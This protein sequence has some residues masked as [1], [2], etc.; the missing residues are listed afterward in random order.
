MVLE[1]VSGVRSVP[2]ND[3]ISKESQ[4]SP[5]SI[6]CEKLRK[7]GYHIISKGRGTKKRKMISCL[8]RQTMAVR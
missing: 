8:I 3:K 2:R 7:A 1:Q 5:Q 6:V 4:R